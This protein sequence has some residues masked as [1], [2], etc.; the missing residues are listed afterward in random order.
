M[1]YVNI[2][3][4]AVHQSKSLRTLLYPLLTVR[5]TLGRRRAAPG[6]RVVDV[7]SMCLA[8]DPVISIPELPGKYAINCRSD[9]FR[10]IALYGI[11]EPELVALCRK[12]ISPDRD[13]VDVG[14][15]IGLYTVLFAS[16]APTRRILAIEPTKG[17]LVRLRRNLLINDIAARVDVFEGV[18]SEQAGELRLSVVLG[19]EEYSTLGAMEHPSLGKAEVVTVSTTASTV[20]LLVKQRK[21]EPGFI[22]IDVEGMEHLVIRGMTEVLPKYR[23]IVLAE[24]CDPLLR[25]NGSSA[26][27]VVSMME[28]LGYTVRVI[29]GD[30]LCV[31]K[32]AT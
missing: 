7:L 17:A 15:N 16:L 13:I 23:P 6:N 8:E 4:S 9:I 29:I 28:A 20:D 5:N 14:A 19:R 32:A 12:H 22:K 2:L 27:E 10:R 24:L 31:P 1:E 26:R 18:V 21:L 11:Y 25:R 3:R 30:M